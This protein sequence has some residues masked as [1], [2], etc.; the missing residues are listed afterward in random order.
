MAETLQQLSVTIFDGERCK[1]IYERAGGKI[2]LQ[3]QLCTGGE[4]NRDFCVGDSGTGLMM[5]ETSEEDWNEEKW[6]LI[7]VTSF[8]PKF[9][10]TEGIPGVL[11][12]VRSYIYWILDNADP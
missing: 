12:R 11:S 7:G 4:N 6:K 10:G 2:S 3:T 1:K 9:C 8:G 5:S